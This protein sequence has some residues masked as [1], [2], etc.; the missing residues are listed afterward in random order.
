MTMSNSDRSALPDIP[1]GIAGFQDAIGASYFPYEVESTE[2]GVSFYGAGTSGQI[3]SLLLA[4]IYASAAF[5]VFRAPRDCSEQRHSYILLLKEF[6]GDVH[7]HNKRSCTLHTGEILLIDSKSALETRQYASGSSLSIS[8][9][10]RALASRYANVDDWCLVPLDTSAGAAA[11]LRECMLCYW[12]SCDQVNALETNDLAAGLV[13][14]IGA[15]FKSHGQLPAFE[16]RS[17]KM[18]FLRIRQVV[19]ENLEDAELSTDFVAHRLGLSKSYIYEIMSSVGM[20]LGRFILAARLDR[21]RELLADPTM[22]N[23]YI[24]D[25]AFSVGFQDLSHFSRR[26]N[27]RFHCSPRDFRAT[28][29]H[30]K[31]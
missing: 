25:I 4:R 8:I 5:S 12:H 13:H 7:F 21:S 31:S 20:T 14:L 23:R 22:A 1:G 9:P 27:E 17:L 28:M 19:F 11:V 3:G 10:A 6:G 24:S 16:S 26:F 18:H 30:T 2:G 29:P 15:A